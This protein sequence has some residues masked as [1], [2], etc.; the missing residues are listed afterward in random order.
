MQITVTLPLSVTKQVP[1][2]YDVKGNYTY[3]YWGNQ[4]YFSNGVPESTFH[5]WVHLTASLNSS[6]LT[7][8]PD[9]QLE[10]LK[11]MA[12][13]VEDSNAPH[14]AGKKKPVKRK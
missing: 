5:R 1:C 4:I 8:T 11:G 6:L 7:R 2:Y 9:E 12:K 3:I 13:L 14:R 10:Y